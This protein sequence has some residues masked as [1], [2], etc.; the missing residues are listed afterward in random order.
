MYGLEGVDAFRWV[1]RSV[2]KPRGDVQVFLVLGSRSQTV[3]LR[4]Y[5]QYR[6]NIIASLTVA[7]F[8]TY[9]GVM[10]LVKPPGASFVVCSRKIARV[11]FK[12]LPHRDV[13]KHPHATF[14]RRKHLP[15]TA[16]Q[17]KHSLWLIFGRLFLSFALPISIPP[18]ATS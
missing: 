5:I 3:D 16:L 14:T 8:E 9:L 12:R 15:S 4:S 2:W 13:N 11:A 18:R 10:F 6:S 17:C 1:A 7:K